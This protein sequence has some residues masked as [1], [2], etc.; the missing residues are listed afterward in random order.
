MNVSAGDLAV[1][2]YDDEMHENVGKLVR[3]LMRSSTGWGTE[4]PYWRCKSLGGPLVTRLHHVA[5]QP[6]GDYAMQMAC[7]FADRNLKRINPPTEPEAIER[8]EELTV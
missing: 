7:H 3:V 8:T 5:G 1:V 6:T 2:T 4:L